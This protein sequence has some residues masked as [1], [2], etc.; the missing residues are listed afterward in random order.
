MP[1]SV[2]IC[3][4]RPLMR[5]G[6]D[7]LLRGEPGIGAAA[8]ADSRRDALAK[9]R[10]G[11]PDVVVIGIRP[12]GPLDAAF[13]RT[14]RSARAESAVVAYTPDDQAGEVLR[15]GAAGVLSATAA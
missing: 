12:G 1:L 9:L 4:D 10:S 7:S 5:E 6:L 2:L 11:R 14:L 15:A 13:V 8:S 3:D